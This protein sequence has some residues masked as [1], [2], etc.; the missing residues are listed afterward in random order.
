MSDLISLLLIIIILVLAVALVVLLRRRRSS[1][2]P[3]EE[4]LAEYGERELPASLEE[5]ELSIPWYERIWLSISRPKTEIGGFTP[6]HQM[7]QARR[8]QDVAT[9]SPGKSKPDAAPQR[10]PEQAAKP[11]VINAPPPQAAPAPPPPAPV[12]PGAMPSMPLPKPAPAAPPPPM[13]MPKPQPVPAAPP[14]PR[15]QET[16]EEADE[17]EAL[18]EFARGGAAMPEAEP[19][20]AASPSIQLEL[21]E[22]EGTATRVTGRGDS[23]TVYNEKMSE[24]L[25][26]DDLIQMVQEVE[27]S[28]Y[29]PK[30]VV[31]GKWEKLHAYIFRSTAADMVEK[32]ADNQLGER[33]AEFRGVRAP[34]IA[35]VPEGALV[36]A[37]PHLDGFQFNPPSISLGFYKDWHRFDFELRTKFA[38]LNQ[39]TNGVVTFT[40]EGIIIADIPLSI[41]VGQ[42]VSTGDVRTRAAAKLY[43]AIFCSYS[44]RDTQIVSRAERAYKALGLDYLR[45]V[46][47]LKSGQEWDEELL[48]LISKADIFQLFWSS[49][50]ADSSYVRQEWEYALKLNRD[51]FIR[52]VYWEEPQPPIPPELGHIHFAYQPD[53]DD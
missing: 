34:A 45:D 3:L 18:G 51:K 43:H 6:E 14:P 39:S 32:D 24:L 52:P 28:A 4:R 47:S 41:Y 1:D 36:T 8:E 19:E 30:E 17:D 50:A 38:P 21:S 29:Y 35:D 22:E 11:P 31:P 37:T 13:S 42:L 25:N 5:I 9:S 16:A 44:H 48:N 33:R 10:Q 53:L 46:I 2:D 27:F 20:P 40:V 26:M 12:A 23:S 15:Q 49:A 7:E